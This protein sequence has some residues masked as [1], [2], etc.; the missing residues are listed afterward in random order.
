MSADLFAAFGD[1][2][3]SSAPQQNQAK[4]AQD[5]FSFLDFASPT[6]QPQTQTQN[7]QQ[8]VPWPPIQQLA[9]TQ[10]SSFL[11]AQ[12]GHPQANN[13][14]VWGDL[15]GL[16]GFQTQTTTAPAPPKASTPVQDDEEDEDDWGDFEAATK[17]ANSPQPQPPMANTASR[18]RVTRA[19]TMDL[20][21][22]K[23]F[24][25]GLEDSLK[26][27]RNPDPDVLFDADFEADNVAEDGDDFGD[28]EAVTPPVVKAAPTRPAQDLLG[29]DMGPAPSS[30]KA[31]PGLTL[32]N[33][34]LH[35]GPSAYPQ[36]PK[37][38]YGSSFHDRKPDLVKE[39]QVKPPTGVRNIQEANEASPSP[40]TAWPEVDEGFG[41]K[42]EEF[43]D[44][45]DT[46]TKPTAGTVQQSKTK[47]TS[48]SKPTLAPVSNSEWEWQDWGATEEKTPE[49]S[50]PP[51]HEPRGPPP[52][53]IPPPSVLLSL[54]PQLL[55]LATTTLLK[56]LLTLSTTSPGYQRII[57]STQTLAFI[58]GY[59]ALAT[60][61]SRL[62]AGRKHRWHR[63]KFLSQSMSISAAAAGGK[64]GMKLSGVDK[65][66]SVREEQEVAEV[67][68]VWKK[69]V[70]RLR[71]VVAAMN[72][73]HHESLKIPELAQ[74][75]AVT[76]AKNVPTAP[77]AC[78][79]CGLKR[80]ERVSKV[81]Y[82]VEDSFGDWWVEFW[83]HRQCANFWVEH[84][85]ELRQ[86]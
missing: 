4:P 21:G 23:L 24:N 13:S 37:S 77:K 25:L 72:T 46:T 16:G 54:C 53:N 36:A 42:W 49:N 58:K 74:N 3:S 60:V 79:V 32:S 12:V 67:I 27:K 80:D 43:K 22:N 29:L 68:E 38:P 35:G 70:G 73:A 86:R 63:D 18:T 40:I 45:P 1:T 78:V 7:T 62:I 66:Q 41:N 6:P 17:P 52:T 61:A 71:G 69:Q 64:P 19:S 9:P 82:E 15:G 48:K 39:L 75:M 30:K 31:P 20:M 76:T 2:P 14:N 44:I 28:F 5:S 65:T 84:E 81:D 26:P 47:T 33:A 83:G 85:K 59:L 8:P 34:A 51:T 55:D 10:G 56:P 57:S 50:N 11:T